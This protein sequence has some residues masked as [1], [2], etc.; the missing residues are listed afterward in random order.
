[1]LHQVQL[2][3]SALLELESGRHESTAGGTHWKSLVWVDH[4]DELDVFSRIPDWQAIF[5]T[6]LPREMLLPLLRELFQVRSVVIQ[7]DEGRRFQLQVDPKYAR[8]KRVQMTN[9]MLNRF[10]RSDSM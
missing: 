8:V 4:G 7:A 6:S 10:H 2:L 9:F 3:V 5:L 1:M